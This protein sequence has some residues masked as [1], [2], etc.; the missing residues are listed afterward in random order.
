LSGTDTSK[1]H[2]QGV[3]L[4]RKLEISSRTCSK[5][6]NFGESNR[7]PIRSS[8][9]KVRIR[10]DS[11]KFANFEQFE[12]S[13]GAVPRHGGSDHHDHKLSLSVK[14]PF[15]DEPDPAKVEGCKKLKISQLVEN[16]AQR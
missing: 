5:F 6:A 4:L 11:S 14:R 3:L 12:N 9:T 10:F 15:S 7:L 16:P 8:K 13:C 2:L 1:T